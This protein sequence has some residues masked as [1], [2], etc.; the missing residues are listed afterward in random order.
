MSRLVVR[1]A[2]LALLLTVPAWSAGL[3]PEPVA[4]D[5]D[6]SKARTL[7]PDPLDFRSLPEEAFTLNHGIPS[8]SHGIGPGSRLFITMQGES[9]GCSAN[10][11]WTDG[12]SHYLGTAGHCVIPE[13][14]H[15]TH[16]P[17]ADFD[18]SGVIVEVCVSSCDF[19]GVTSFMIPGGLVTLG[20]V[21]YARSTDAEGVGFGNDFALVKIPEALVSR[22]RPGL[23]AFGGPGPMGNLPTGAPVCHYGHGVGFGEVYATQARIGFNYAA[24]SDGSWLAAAAVNK[25]DSGSAIVACVRNGSDFVATRA[26]GI[27]THGVPGAAIG[28]TTARAAQ[29]ATEAGL[30]VTVVQG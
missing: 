2:V 17:D 26:Y 24:F 10:F 1:C 5:V 28:T 6:L 7:L 12:T 23:P 13:G 20:P 9:F 16:G 27:V 19:G 11:V 18:A 25:G 15:A 8:K 30:S 29:L 22:I 21:V 3:D 4:P 14:K